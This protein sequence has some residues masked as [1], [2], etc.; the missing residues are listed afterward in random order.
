MN[1]IRVSPDICR[2]GCQRGCAIKLIKIGLRA[3]IVDALTDIPVG[4]S[5]V[6]WR[7][8]Q[9]KASPPGRFPDSVANCLSS[10]AIALEAAL[11]VHIYNSIDRR[12]YGYANA[13]DFLKAY[14]VFRHVAQGNK[15][16]SNTLYYAI[17]DTRSGVV[18]FVH[19]AT[20]NGSYIYCPSKKNTRTCPFCAA[21]SPKNKGT[22][23]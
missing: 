16:D 3:P 9:G 19:C 14:S 2:E 12:N 6:L 23:S 4:Q 10:V 11:F 22:K 13:P 1:E 8:L 18:K 15:I 17:R 21:I 20:C 5:N 7:D